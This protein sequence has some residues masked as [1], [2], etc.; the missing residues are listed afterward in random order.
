MKLVFIKSSNL[1]EEPFTTSK[2]IAECGNVEHHTVTK[3]IQ[4]YESDLEEFGRLRFEIEPLKTKGG[5]QNTKYYKLSEQQATLLITYMKNTLTVRKFKKDLVKQFYIMREELTKRRFE[6]NNGIEKR[7][8]LTAALDKLPKSPHKPM[9]Y[10]HYTDLVYNIVFSKNTKQLRQEFGISEK[11]TPR[12][13]LSVEDI[14][15]VE[16]MENEIAVLIDFGNSYSDIKNMMFRKHRK[17]S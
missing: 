2:V 4:T 3:L 17:I 14:K 11:E 12:D 6:R 15:K 1:N 8:V 5:V 7:N 16:K 10:K 13:Y 9:M